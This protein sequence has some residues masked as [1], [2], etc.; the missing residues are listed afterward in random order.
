LLVV[1][2]HRWGK[3]LMRNIRLF[4]GFCGG[5]GEMFHGGNGDA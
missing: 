2:F 5:V 3:V 1:F 4:F